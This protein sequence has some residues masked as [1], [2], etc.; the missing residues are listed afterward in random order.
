MTGGGLSY[1]P[2]T[3]SSEAHKVLSNALLSASGP[4]H[5]TH[6]FSG[7]FHGVPSHHLGFSSNITSLRS[8]PQ[9]P[10]SKITLCIHSGRPNKMPQTGRLERHLLL[11]FR[12]LE[13][14]DQGA[15][16]VRA[17]L[18]ACRKPPSPCPHVAFPGG[19]CG[20]RGCSLL[21][22]PLLIRMPVLAD[23]DPTLMT[24]MHPSHL[25]RTDPVSTHRH[26]GD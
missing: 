15:V 7:N 3:F 6:S 25:L 9:P 1:N 17:L 13:V 12:K 14:R 21:A 19:A 18:P 11:Q 8:A 4:L 5:P 2:G 20:W 24:P 16:P 26:A 22:L 23:Q 10:P